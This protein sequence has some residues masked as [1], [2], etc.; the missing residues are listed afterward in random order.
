MM[1]VS[2]S[3]T[4]ACL[5]LLAH[6]STLFVVKCANKIKH[7]KLLDELTAI[8]ANK[9]ISKVAPPA[10]QRVPS[11]STSHDTTAP[12]VVRQTKHIHSRNTR[13]NTPMPLITEAP[14]APLT[15]PPQTT[16]YD[17]PRPT[18]STKV[19]TIKEYKKQIETLHTN[20]QKGNSQRLPPNPDYIEPD[21]DR[22]SQRVPKNTRPAQRV[23]AGIHKYVTYHIP[24]PKPTPKPNKRF[25]NLIAPCLPRISNRTQL[26]S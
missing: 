18:S 2:L 7:E 3:N 12:R 19:K 24:T 26:P 5:I 9:P 8:I 14:I 21:D 13:S 25:I 11:P 22:P 15:P 10:P 4:F 16:W 23:P 1:A 20:F 17:K 6:P